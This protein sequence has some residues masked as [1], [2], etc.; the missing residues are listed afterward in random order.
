MGKDSIKQPVGGTK[1][2]NKQPPFSKEYKKN[3]EGNNNLIPVLSR[4]HHK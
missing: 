2:L 4:Q 3:K 1:L